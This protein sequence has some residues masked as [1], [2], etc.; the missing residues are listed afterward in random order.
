MQA[1]QLRLL[2]LVSA[3]LA[4]WH[5]PGVG[6]AGFAMSGTWNHSTE[7]PAVRWDYPVDGLAV[8]GFGRV[9]AGGGRQAVA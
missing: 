3:V 6:K 9:G 5:L 8:T 7:S 4:A 1:H 2:I